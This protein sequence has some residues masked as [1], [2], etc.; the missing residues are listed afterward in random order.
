MQ[1]GKFSRLFALVL[2]GGGLASLARAEV[3]DYSRDIQPLFAEHCL[4][5]HGPDASK[6][7][8]VLT[9]RE[10]ALKELK[11]GAHGVV[12]GDPKA[13]ALLQRV[14]TTDL[15][16][17]M[18]PKAKK[19]LKPREIELL[20]S[21][22][23]SGA[24]Y[25]QHWAYKPLSKA[26]Q[27]ASVGAVLRLKPYLKLETNPHPI[28][29]F[30][31]TKLAEKGIQP[32]PEA[33][34]TTLIKRVH[35]DV[36][37]L[38]P[39]PA[40]V[41]AF[42]QDSS[43]DAYSAMVDRALAS[44][45]YGER[46]G[47]HW[48][49]A[50]RYADSDGYE[51]DRARPDAWRYR[52]WVIRAV[53]DDMP[54]DQFTI[55]QIAGDLLPDPTPEQWVATAF[56][57]QTLTNTEGGTDQE[58][59]RIEAVM[60]RVETIGAVW[61]GLTVGCARCHT[62][63]YDQISHTEYY[64]M[65]AFFN[66]GDEVTRQVPTTPEVWQ[67]YEKAHG[68]AARK[69]V[70][71][72][73]R[74]DAARAELPAQLPEW[75]SA[76]QARL[77]EARASQAKAVYSPLEI[78]GIKA[79]SKATFKKLDDGSHLIGGKTAKEDVYDLELKPTPNPLTALRLEVLPDASLPG[80]GP[81]RSKNGNFVLSEFKVLRGKSVSDAVEIPVHSPIADFEQKGFTAIAVLD[82]DSQT[83][84]AVSGAVGKAHHL[85]VQLAEPVRL[86][87]DERFFVRLE[88]RYA[89]SGAEHVIGRLRLSGSSVI[90]E[91]S[92]APPEVVKILGEEPKRRNPVVVKP[93]WDWLEKVDPT[94]VAA[95]VAL[96]Q[97]QARLPKPPLMDAR[98]IAQRSS[99]PRATRLLLRGDFLQ[100]A[101]VVMPASLAVLPPLKKP[102]P[103]RLDFARWLVSPENPL[104]PR[105]TVNSIWGRLFGEGL[106]RTAADFGVRGEKPTHPELLDWLA[107]E[108]I[109]QGW[110]RK[111]LL[112]HILT[113]ATYKQE[114]KH[115]AEMLEIDPR[116][117]L[118]WRQNRLRVEGEIVR[119]LYLAASGLLSP[120]IGGPSVFPPMPPDVAALSY[121]GNFSWTT[122]RGED[123]Y[124]RGLYTFFKRTA[125]HP[126]LTTFDCPDANTTNVKRTVSNTPL[127]ALTT[128]NAEAFGE[129]AQALSRRVLKEK[130]DN[131]AA[132]LT[133][134]FRLCLARSPSSSELGALTTLLAD[135]R[136]HY[137]ENAV[138]ATAAVGTYTVPG[139]TPAE[140]AAWIATA[141]ILLNMDEFIT[142]E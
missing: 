68:D 31:R 136:R 118:L 30:V 117:Q 86:K 57:R 37:G 80:Q 29:H 137:G 110:S 130:A 81:G 66:N 102:S 55:E 62:H 69:L 20:K 34:K 25:D 22:I 89:K 98:V 138:D 32:S 21:W 10:G 83:G 84:W 141:R 94:V 122:S 40:E 116:N 103:T 129:A 24:K 11:S 131:D 63:K 59:F 38:P 44:Q 96:Q 46:W 47:R 113:S 7:G 114:S 121:A 100:P 45:H 119:D 9:T 23:Q 90:T 65:F 93:L 108:F 91:E 95:R 112:R 35:Y 142:R 15:E 104:T 78:A 18:P 26:S 33:D 49:D 97:A 48:L 107:G 76:V 50:A 61:L 109:R 17:R 43:P 105:V 99:G 64:Q 140:T 67:A 85:T 132:R 56:H 54:F 88:Q 36:L 106:V 139:T 135:A 71:L 87:P 72:Q 19:P 5:C 127:Q 120:K 133:H 73:Q 12:P 4:E 2:I 124:R 70:P 42:L 128:L 75:E 1:N 79:D 41:D 39:S 13:S 27:T 8:L 123:R 111:K 115:R 28:D 3:A 92:I 6:G 125:P 134:A 16:D 60:D 101:E 58:Q 126:D 82:G 53:N 52:D 77:R 14:L 74:L 51:K